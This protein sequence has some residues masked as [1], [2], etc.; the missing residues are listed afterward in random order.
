MEQRPCSIGSLVALLTASTMLSGCF[1]HQAYLPG[2]ID[3][4]TDGTGLPAPAQPPVADTRQTRSGVERYV[5]GE[6][7]TVAGTD[8]DI[9]DRHYWVVGLIPLANDSPAPE[10]AAAQASSDALIRLEIG[11]ELDALSLIGAIV[12][13]L[14]VPVVAWVAPPWSF[15]LHAKA[16]T[17]RPAGVT[18]L[19]QPMPTPGPPMPPPAAPAPSP[20]PPV[21]PPPPE[22]LS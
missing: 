16:V 13:Q 20:P 12:A 9:E 2:V 6:G 5:I 22:P 14:V 1:H 7:L 19:P 8:V 17:T 18:P 3:L 10:I 15:R 21:N 4:R 11:E